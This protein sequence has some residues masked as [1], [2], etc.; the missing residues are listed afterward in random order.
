MKKCLMLACTLALAGCMTM[1]AQD[2]TRADWNMLGYRDGY[3]GASTVPESKSLL[4]LYTAEC[5]PHGTKPDAVAY[6]KG[7]ETGSQNRLY[8]WGPPARP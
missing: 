8:W 5:A 2:C 7:L 6:A 1:N 3:S 4:N